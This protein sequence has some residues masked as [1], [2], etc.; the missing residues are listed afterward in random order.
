MIKCIPGPISV[1][2]SMPPQSPKVPSFQNLSKQYI[3]LSLTFTGS[4]E[5]GVIF[6]PQ[7]L[8]KRATQ[9]PRGHEGAKTTTCGIIFRRNS[10]QSGGLVQQCNTQPD[11]TGCYAIETIKDCLF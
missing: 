11:C 3:D 10:S 4:L 8:I 9:I 2:M 6:S 7:E 5:R 1:N